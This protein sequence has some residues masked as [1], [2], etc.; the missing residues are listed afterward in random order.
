MNN[1]RQIKCR[2]S[3]SPTG[4][5]HL[6]N[7]RTALFSAL[8]SHHCKGI[9]L[10]RIEDT[11]RSRSSEHFTQQLFEDLRWLGIEWDE[12]GDVGGPNGPYWQSQRQ[13]IYDQ[14]YHQL[15]AKDLIY[16]CFC[17]EEQLALA[18]KVQR[19]SGQP[20]RY[21]GTC[22]SL[23]KDE[24]QAKIAKGIKPTIRFKIPRG[25][26][27]EFQDMV[28]GMQRFKSDDIGDFIIKRADGNSPFMYCNAIDDALMNV[29][30]V[31][32]GEDHLTNSP[33]QIMILQALALPIPTYCH[34]S[35]IVGEDNSKLSKRQGSQNIKELREEGYLSSALVNYLARLGHYYPDNTFM[36]MPQLAQGFALENL[37]SSP[38]RFDGD[39]LTFWQKEAVT[40][41]DEDSF[42]Q[43]C[44][45]EVIE[46]VPETSK[47]LFVETVRPNVFLPADALEWANKIFNSE[48]Q[49]SDESV[50]ILLDAGIEFF[51]QALNGVNSHGADFKEISNH[52]KETTGAK[53]KNLFQPLRVALT[54]QL[55]GP[56]MVKLVELMGSKGVEQRFKQVLQQFS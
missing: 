20:P 28:K 12:G 4:F 56:E 29:T 34:I 36:N 31:I 37:S 18:R 3:P 16:P 24:I 43:W 2:F 11:D 5:M 15:E 21:S 53:G 44:G 55:H 41:L 42:W 40:H 10:I 8:Y 9:F 6:G 38:A 13:D 52:V 30:H 32:R 51:R 48:I 35:L 19:A 26:T 27:I 23:S 54:D 49:Y 45:T 25:E 33:R 50:N 22:R 7:A 17:T 46:A 1:K 47:T 39:Q 14:F